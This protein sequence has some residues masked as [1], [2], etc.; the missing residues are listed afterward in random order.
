VR[1]GVLFGDNWVAMSLVVIAALLATGDFLATLFSVIYQRYWYDRALR[2]KYSPAYTPPCAVIVPCK[3]LM[4][5]FE[6]NVRSFL[7][8]EYPA[9]RVYYVVEH[10][11][12]PAVETLRAVTAERPE[13]ATLVVAGLAT[14][15]AQKN[16]NLLAAVRQAHEAEVFAFADADIGP[17]GNWLRELLLPLSASEVSVTTGFRWLSTE[18]P[19][20]G[21]MV[22][23]YIS[24]FLYVLLSVASFFG[25]V[26]VWGGSMAIRRRDF[27]GMDIEGL[28]SRSVVDDISLSSRVREMGKQTVMVPTCVTHTDDLIETVSGGVIW[29]ERQIMFLKAY[30]RGLWLYGAAPITLLGAAIMLW[31]PFAL[32]ASI[33]EQRTFLAVGG[34]A[35]LLLIAGEA[36]TALLY[37]LLGEMPRFGRFLALQP[38][39]RSMHVLSYLRTMFTNVV[40][41]SGVRYYLDR[42]GIVTRVERKS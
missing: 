34:A 8:L 4:K 5:N 30:H 21:E 9:Y 31:L 38:F 17:R 19:G 27:E 24:I 25:E 3:G 20:V 15:C 7:D 41:W 29:F 36:V 28:W 37:P 12:D 35:P 16:H 26:G 11:T 39:M 33:G 22:H 14:R 18:K 10:E 40:T 2:P 32:V 1:F 23:N 6:H 13:R 42:Q